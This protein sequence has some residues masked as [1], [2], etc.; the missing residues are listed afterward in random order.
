MQLA[1]T[2]AAAVPDERLAPEHA[3]F[4]FEI[5]SVDTFDLRTLALP[6][7]CGANGGSD[8]SHGKLHKPLLEVEAAAPAASSQLLHSTLMP[9]VP[10]A[11]ASKPMAGIVLDETVGSGEGHKD[12]GGAAGGGGRLRRARAT[13]NTRENA[14]DSDYDV[15][16]DAEDEDGPIGGSGKVTKD[17]LVKAY[18]LPINE[19]AASLNMGVT[20]LK[21]YC[22]RFKI[23]RWPFRKLSSIAK[24]IDT[25]KSDA[26]ANPDM[27][28][29]A[30]S[31]LAKL[32]DIRQC[33]YIDTEYQLPEEIKKLRQA[34]FK[35]EYKHR[36]GTRVCMAVHSA[37]P[38]TDGQE[39]D[40]QM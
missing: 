30:A 10:P 12:E 28:S 18:H 2:V 17:M 19:A 16:D 34:H 8:P 7:E 26:E 1:R 3:A 37:V 4:K 39:E 15:D 38:G 40:V 27:V 20:V 32:E 5:E 33:I 11:A 21:K 35:N 14:S 6:E 31:L 36:Q 9:A 25:V 13:R 22:R 24:L 29:T 23:V